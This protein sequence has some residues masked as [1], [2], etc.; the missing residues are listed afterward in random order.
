MKQR[1]GVRPGIG[2]R[3]RVRGLLWFLGVTTPS[4]RGLLTKKGGRKK[5]RKKS[6]REKKEAHLHGTRL[7][8][9]DF[10]KKRLFL[11]KEGERTV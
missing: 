9:I 2:N 4:G 8:L 1:R 5:P 3:E 11:F 10:G 7:S 6:N